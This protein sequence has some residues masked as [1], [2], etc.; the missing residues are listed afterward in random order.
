MAYGPLETH[1]TLVGQI[2]PTE[3]RRADVTTPLSGIVVQPL[4][5][6]GQHVGQ[7]EALA[8][9][10]NVYGTTPMQLQQKID[11][12][13]SSVVSSQ[14]AY[15]AAI[16]SLGQARATLAQSQTTLSQSIDNLDQAKAELVNAATDYRR[17]QSGLKVGVN[18]Q[19]D[20]DDARERY[21]KAQAVVKD[22][23]NQVQLARSGVAIASKN[24]QPAEQN[25]QL[26]RRNITL[27][28]AQ[29]EHDRVI[30]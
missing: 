25:V 23:E 15:Q 17:K 9:I 11:T 22:S 1:L 28:Q 5:R 10:N 4:V 14:N 6:V 19:T 20:V 26:T 16:A 21:W 2:N 8:E 18:A 12:D 13:Q 30:M 3:H 27:A 24:I 29:V 7:G